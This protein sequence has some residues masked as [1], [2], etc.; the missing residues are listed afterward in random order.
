MSLE[1][2]IQRHYGVYICASLGVDKKMPALEC[3][4]CCCV[5]R[6]YDPTRAWTGGPTILNV[7]APIPTV[8]VNNVKLSYLPTVFLPVTDQFF[9]CT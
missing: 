6:N 3:V 4:T 7:F 9:L 2:V 1:Q 5:G 8:H